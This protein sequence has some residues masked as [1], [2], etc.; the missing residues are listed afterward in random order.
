MSY[1]IL[2]FSGRYYI[3]L[4]NTYNYI[5]LNNT[6][7]YNIKKKDLR[8]MGMKFPKKE[9]IPMTDD[10]LIKLKT[11]LREYIKDN[12]KSIGNKM[13]EMG[14]KLKGFNC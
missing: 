9:V 8:L 10:E 13:V 5:I 6:K 2:K 7:Y 12:E 11:L 4:S 14:Y 3:N 1:H